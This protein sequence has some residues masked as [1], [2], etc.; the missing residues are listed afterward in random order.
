MTETTNGTVEEVGRVCLLCDHFYL[1]MGTPGYS[2]LTPGSD[3]QMACNKSHW[4]FEQYGTKEHYASCIM[5]AQ[6]CTDYKLNTQFL[7]QINDHKEVQRGK[8]E[9]RKRGRRK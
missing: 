9:R 1:S 2:E 3:F 5:T 7:V 6:T 4:D 8:A